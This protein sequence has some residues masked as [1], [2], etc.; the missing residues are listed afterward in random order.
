MWYHHYYYNYFITIIITMTT[1][2]YH[3]HFLIIA[4]ITKSRVYL[5]MLSLDTADQDTIPTIPHKEEPQISI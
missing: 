3:I 1:I 4:K 5:L 2:I